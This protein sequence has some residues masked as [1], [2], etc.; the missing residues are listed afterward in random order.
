MD[1]T[2]KLAQ[3]AKEATYADFPREVIDKAKDAI[4]D[5]LGCELAGSTLPW[6]KATYKYVRDGKAGR[7][8]S[9][10]VNY[11]LKTEA[12]DAAFANANFGRGIEGDD[13]DE[14]SRS[15]LASV[16]IPT[17]L[18]IGEREMVSGKELIRA[19]V[20][21]YDVA[22][23]IGAA[24]SWA[25]RRGFHPTT[26]L[27]PFGA[28]T[29]TSV[30]LGLDEDEILGALGIAASHSSGLMEYSA[31][32]GSVNRLHAGIAAYGGIRSSFLAQ[33][34]FSGPATILEGGKGFCQAFSDECSLEEITRGLGKEFKILGL[35]FRRY[36]C[37]GTQ[38]A[39]LDA[40]SK[41][42]S[43]H[44]LT[45]QDVGEIVV[46]VPNSILRLIGT[47]TEPKD[48]TSAQFSG[49]FGVALRI[50]KGGN[51]FREYFNEENL[52]DPEILSLIGKT[53]FVPDDDLEKHPLSVNPAGLTMRLVDGTVYEETVY[54][55]KGAIQD[56]LAKEELQNKFRDLASMALPQNKVADIAEAIAGLEGL[57]DIAHLSSLLHN[58]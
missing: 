31:S 36:C 28:A 32:G 4:L 27:G 25:I 14:A 40:V 16:I 20:V 18:A 57:D 55:A 41:I 6:S 19:V 10:V 58:G 8:E 42:V 26:I 24:V 49:R 51:G 23:R 22:L 3:F 50:A 17:A 53:K 56:P 11:G 29:A 54:A 46:R 39:A 44:A 48:M 33:R 9:T 35:G 43:E 12:Q 45:P 7:E 37:C 13:I 5:Q 1:E 30:L 38:N 47:I 2:R 52:R 15:H 34:G 21:G